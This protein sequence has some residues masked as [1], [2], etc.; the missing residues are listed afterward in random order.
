MYRR[1]RRRLSHR[2]AV[3]R[4]WVD[5][6]AERRSVSP[7]TEAALF[8]RVEAASEAAEAAAE[9]EDAVAVAAAA[10]DAPTWR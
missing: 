8:R 4:A 10:G 5:E 6:V 2:P 3:K 7:A 9:V 1:E